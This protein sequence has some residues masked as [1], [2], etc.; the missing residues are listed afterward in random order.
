MPD[1]AATTPAPGAPQTAVR[2]G[3]TTVASL[4]RGARTRAAGSPDPTAWI[5]V[6]DEASLQ[7]HAARATA[8]GPQAPL[9]GLT[10]AVKDNI[11]VAGAPT[12]AACPSFA[13]RPERSATVVERL[14]DAGAVP[15]G[16]TNLDQF[17]TGLVGTRSPYGA[18][19]SVADP[20]YVSGGSSSGSA[21]AVARGE[22][23]MAL[24]T[25]TAGS[26]RVPAGFNGIV[27]LKPTRGRLSTAGVVPACRSLDCVS[28][29]ARDV[30]TAATVLGALDDRPR[31][32]DPRDPYHRARPAGPVWTGLASRA[33]AGG[34]ARW[35]VAVDRAALNDVGDDASRAAWAATLDALAAVADIVDV[36]LA[37]FV[38]AGELLYGGPWTAERHVAV[39][40]FLAGDPPDADPTVRSIILGGAEPAATAAFAAAHRLQELRARTSPVLADVDALLVPTAPRHPTVA[41]VVADPIGVNAQLGRFTNFVNLLDLCGI[42]VPGPE[43]PDALPFGITFLAPAWEDERLLELGAHWERA[44]AGTPERPAATPVD[45]SGEIEVVVAGAHLAGLPANPQLT[46]RDATFVRLTRTAAGHGLRIVE[47]PL[48]VRPGLV[49]PVAGAA[50]APGSAGQVEVEV[51]RIAADRFG[52]LA[53]EVPEG[54]ALGPVALLDGTRRI[55]F[56]AAAADTGAAAEP[57]PGGWRDH[58]RDR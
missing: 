26:G 37:P 54:L 18:P 39:G 52:S 56:V 15:V 2:T 19:R 57:L 3:A 48:G 21:V 16:K 47:T 38:E 27:G 17:A 1:D 29:F 11:D 24:G 44:L 30:D 32:L 25:D 36:D 9:A 49:R 42:A 45:G 28:V 23:D 46:D 55:G 6:L 43:R 31:D 35:R 7:T 34:A 33:A 13:Y 20:E 8:A 40:T 22:V 58:V 51:W 4:A 5:H 10:V 41:E 50:A 14:I 53:G 12:T